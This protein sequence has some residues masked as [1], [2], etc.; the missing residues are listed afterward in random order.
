[1][2]EKNLKYYRLRSGLSKRE[3][4]SR[5]GV[6][7]MAISHYENGERKPEI[8]ILRRLAGALGV[9]LA[10]FLAVRGGNHQYVHCEFRKNRALSKTDE[11]LI[12]ES[13][14]EYFD[15]F[16]HVVDALGGEVL[17][18][19]PE[20]HCVWVGVDAEEAAR[21]LRTHL[22]FAEEGPIQNLVGAMENKGVLIFRCGIENAHFSGM[23]GTVDGRPYLILN[24]NMSPERQRSTLVHELA[25]VFCVFP[26]DMPEKE[27]EDFATA[28]SGAF[29]C[30]R[31][32]MLREL[33]VRR[34]RISPDMIM[35]AKE[36]GVSALLLMKRVNLLGIISDAAYKDF[37]I[38]ASQNGW[39]KNE[40]SRIPEE[41]TN[42][43]EQLTIRA[44]NE[45]EISQQRGAELLNLSYDEFDRM[46]RA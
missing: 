13:V 44:V 40:P 24:A 14:E 2:F 9:K 25:H 3:L 28:I 30:P 27:R 7:A 37:M 8:D 45:D 42:L 34:T 46:V 16:F 17:P 1:M 15:R 12:C 43:F 39:R 31:E 38:R 19:C 20:I 11:E 35:V 4:A 23:N 33:G 32:D 5:I 41:M 26:D 22:G 29:L 36:Y 10:D 21:L 18:A 6:S